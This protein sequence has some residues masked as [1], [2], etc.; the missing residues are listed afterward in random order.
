M[1]AFGRHESW[2]KAIQLVMRS[3]KVQENQTLIENIKDDEPKLNL[4]QNRY[5][6]LIE[7]F[8]SLSNKDMMS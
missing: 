1:A 8:A 5:K 2:Q 4:F 6:W 3:K 7:L